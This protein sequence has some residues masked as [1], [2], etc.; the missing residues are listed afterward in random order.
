[1][2]RLHIRIDQYRSRTRRLT[3][4]HRFE[5]NGKMETG[6]VKAIKLRF[7]KLNFSSS[8]PAGAFGQQNVQDLSMGEGPP[9]KRPGQ[10]AAAAEARSWVVVA[11]DIAAFGVRLRRFQ[12]APCLHRAP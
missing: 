5:R 3:A 12:R 11:A 10:R 7:R 1:M 6:N 8:A 9:L 4:D 2:S